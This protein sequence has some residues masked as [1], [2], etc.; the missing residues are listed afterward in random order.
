MGRLILA[1]QS[2]GYDYQVVSNH[3]L[4]G[5]KEPLS[6]ADEVIC[7]YPAMNSWG[8]L[9]LAQGRFVNFKRFINIG[10]PCVI[11]N[12]FLDHWAGQG[13]IRQDAYFE[14]EHHHSL[15][16][17]CYYCSHNVEEVLREINVDLVKLIDS[18]WQS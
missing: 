6:S 7:V 8:T 16:E 2:H 1:D 3:L 14:V 9:G 15:V 11:V 4:L 17:E 10:L 13:L 12:N 5:G 18:G